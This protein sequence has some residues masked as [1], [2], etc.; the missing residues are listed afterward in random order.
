MSFVLGVGLVS[1]LS[2]LVD[3]QVTDFVSLFG[4]EVVG[5]LHQRY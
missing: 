4:Q 1:P 5:L 3:L 2:L